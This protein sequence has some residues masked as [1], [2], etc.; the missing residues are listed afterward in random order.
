MKLLTAT[1]L[2]AALTMPLMGVAPIL[3]DAAAGWGDVTEPASRY[4]LDD[5]IEIPVTASELERCRATIESV[6]LS[7]PAKGAVA[8]ASDAAGPSV[9]CVVN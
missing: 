7:S 8:A 1:T 3:S 6:F 9:R 2:C 5:V 4:D